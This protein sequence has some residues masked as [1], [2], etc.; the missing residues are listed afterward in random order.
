MWQD[1]EYVYEGPE[2][3]PPYILTSCTCHKLSNPHWHTHDEIESSNFMLN[4]NPN[5]IVYTMNGV[6]Y[7][8]QASLTH[9]CEHS[10][11][12]AIEPTV[13]HFTLGSNFFLFKRSCR[14]FKPT[15]EAQSECVCI[16]PWTHWCSLDPT[17]FSG[18]ATSRTGMHTHAHTFRIWNKII[19]ILK[20]KKKILISLC[21]S[22]REGCR[23]LGGAGLKKFG[24]VITVTTFGLRFSGE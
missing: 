1:W 8:S 15:T 4:K 21:V 22:V 24:S 18:N 7:M 10:T 16:I 20:K 9:L 5:Y 14:A 6:F 11:M 12:F 17:V 2:Q 19:L 23:R 3:T 13:L